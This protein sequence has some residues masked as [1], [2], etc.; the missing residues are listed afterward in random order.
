MK[1]TAEQAAARLMAGKKTGM[2]KTRSLS[3]PT[4]LRTVKDGGEAR[5]YVFDDNGT[6][7]ITPAD[8]SLPAVMGNFVMP[9]SEEGP[10][11]VPPEVAWWLST[12]AEDIKTIQDEETDPEDEDDGPEPEAPGETDDDDPEPTVPPAAA[13]T[14]LLD[15]IKWG[16]T[17][18]WNAQLDFGKGRCF[19]GCVAT[20]ISQVTYYFARKG[21]RRG[22]VA[23]K[24]YT[25]TYHDQ[26]YTMSALA[27]VEMFDF[28]N[29]FAAK[30]GDESAAQVLAVS[31]FCK[32]IGHAAEMKYSTAAS[33]APMANVKTVLEDKLRLGSVYYTSKPNAKKMADTVLPKIRES[34]AKGVPVIMCGGNSKAAHCFV[35]DGYDANSN[36]YHI[37]WGYGGD[38]DGW[39]PMDALKE[40]LTPVSSFGT[41]KYAYIDTTNWTWKTSSG[42]NTCSFVPVYAGQLVRVK[43]GGNGGHVEF[44]TTK[45]TTGDLD[46]ASTEKI[47]W[48]EPGTYD[49]IAP[50]RHYDYDKEAYVD[51]DAKYLYIRRYSSSTKVIPNAVEKGYDFSYDKCFAILQNVPPILGDVNMDGRINMSD[52]TAVINENTGAKAASGVYRKRTGAQIRAVRA[53]GAEATD[54]CIDLGLPSGTLWAT[55]NVGASQPHD[56]GGYFMWG[57]TEPRTRKKDFDWSKYTHYDSS[58]KKAIDIGSNIVGT[59]YDAA[60][61]ILGDGW[62]MPTQ[63]QWEEL[64]TQCNIRIVRRGNMG[65]VCEMKRGDKAIYFPLA[66]CAYNADYP[67]PYTDDMAVST[68]KLGAYWSGNADTDVNK[69]IA[70]EMTKAAISTTGFTRAA[71]ADVNFDGIVDDNDVQL[72]TDKILGRDVL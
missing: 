43:I 19:V 53:A 14:G 15:D 70:Y 24:E 54:K 10:V 25:R 1:I 49:F 47:G 26:T 39:F 21:I 32:H 50:Y 11:T 31:K 3:E 36:T 9:S 67:K 66:G 59:Q 20:A 4:L 22:C 48:L 56:Y 62:Q 46:L 69:A 16:Q 45:D 41:V 68:G 58:T 27:A 5:V 30:E 71:R 33:G 51:K 42:S 40:G 37:N 57:E 72:I 64:I 29:M 65:V 7:V 52:V 8:D 23:T 18:P 61:A 17:Y 28:K 2:R 60:K 12:Y 6:G 63:E 35:C 44:M 38:F 13:E 34:L 55:C